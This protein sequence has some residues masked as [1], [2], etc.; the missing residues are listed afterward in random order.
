MIRPLWLILTSVF[1]GVVG[2]LS[3]KK[4][5]SYLGPISLN[6]S[7]LFV[8]LTRMLT[9]PFVLFGL[10]L[11]AISAVL[12]LAVLSRVQLSYA[13]PM[14]SIGYVLILILSWVFLNERLVYLRILGVLLICCGV[15]L[16]SRS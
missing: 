1:L 11:Y 12:W 10:F 14:I 4:G 8:N 2:Q 13:Y 3:M 7:T 16:V 5:M 6:L 9:S 15:F